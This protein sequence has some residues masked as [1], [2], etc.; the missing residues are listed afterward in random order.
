MKKLFLLAFFALAIHFTTKAQDIIVRTDSS[1]I[2]AKVSEVSGSEVRYKRFDNPNG[3]T[4]TVST[5]DVARIIYQN[6]T[7]DVFISRG[8][9]N[10]DYHADNHLHPYVQKPV[11]YGNY[12]SMN[13]FD[14][15]FG[16]LTVNYE[17]NIKNDFLCLRVPLSVGLSSLG[18]NSYTG[19][20]YADMVYYYNRYKTF[21]TGAELLVYPRGQGFASYF[22]G[23]VAEIG[24]Y[25]YWRSSYPYGTTVHGTDTFYS[26]GIKNGVLIQAAEKFNFSIDCALGVVHSIE[27]DEYLPMGRLG[28]NMGFRF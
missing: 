25:E 14:L 4:Y 2:Q 5:A 6:G 9:G 28:I 26:I 27:D 19:H 7:S 3:P 15:L 16:I 21:S 23:P 8:G 13:A 18:S 11:K 10:D 17:R 12:V 24:A 1:R 22:T 20:Y